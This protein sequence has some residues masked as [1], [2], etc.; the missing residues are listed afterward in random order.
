MKKITTIVIIA[1]C[2]LCIVLPV[3]AASEQQGIHASIAA[4]AA[5]DKGKAHGDQSNDN[6]KGNANGRGDNKTSTTR[7]P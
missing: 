4:G 6:N 1:L 5:D 3:I 2:F 7:G